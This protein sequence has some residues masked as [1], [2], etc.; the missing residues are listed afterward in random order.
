LPQLLGLLDECPAPTQ[1]INRAVSRRRRD[2]RTGVVRDA[3]LW[4][5]LERDDECFLDR[6]FGEIEI[7]EYPDERRDRPTGFLAKQPIDD[8]MSVGGGRRRA[9]SCVGQVDVASAA[10]AP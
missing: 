8:S 1:T 5:R 7:A 4:P 9:R 3:A 6:L 2:P 10:F